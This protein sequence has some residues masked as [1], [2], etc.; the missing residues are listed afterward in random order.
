[1]SNTP[2]QAGSNLTRNII[3][4]TSTSDI[5]DHKPANGS[6]WPMLIGSLEE[7]NDREEGN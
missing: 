7:G 3:K 1:M 5:V 2:S 4:L 6:V